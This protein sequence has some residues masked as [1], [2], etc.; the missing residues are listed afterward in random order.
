[1]KS[2]RESLLGRIPHGSIEALE[3]RRV[4]AADLSAEILS[5]VAGATLGAGTENRVVIAVTNSGT[6]G[7]ASRAGLA[8]YASTDGTFDP[9]SD[10]L[11][12]ART[13]SALSAGERETEDI[14]F[15]LPTNLTAGTYQLFAR[16]DG[17]NQ[18]QESDETNNVSAAVSVTL[19]G[20]GGGS[21]GTDDH[22]GGGSGGSDDNGGGSGGGS[23]GS[24][25][26]GG[27]SGGSD[28]S[29]GGSGGGSGG[30]D[31]NGGGSG[32][33]S[34][35]GSDL[36]VTMNTPSALFVPNSEQH[37][38]VSMTN[39][40]SARLRGV[41]V[42]VYVMTGDVADPTVDTLLGRRNFSS[43]SAGET[44]TEDVEFRVPGTVSAGTRRIYAVADPSN[45]VTETTESNNISA[46]V[47]ASFD[48]AALDLSGTI[49]SSRISSN[50]VA[51][52]ATKST[53]SYSIH[54]AG[55][56]QF[57]SRSSAHVRAY[58]RPV[59][60]DDSSQDIPVSDLKRENLS[61]L[62]PGK[63]RSRELKISIPA[64]VNPGE[65]TLVL[66]FDDSDSLH[67]SDEHNNAVHLEDTIRIAAP[68]V[69]LSASRALMT[70]SLASGRG[71]RAEA[72]VTNSGNV[73]AKGQATITFVLRT[74]QGQDTVIGT[75]TRKIEIKAGKISSLGKVTLRLP[76]GLAAGNYTLV[77]I[78]S[79]ASSLNDATPDNNSV[80]VGPV[81]IG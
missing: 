58:L 25:D 41:G 79:P 75:V 81:Q 69:D 30:S 66:S 51:G 31:D 49:R 36:T 18:H 59:G 29:G 65:Y 70:G 53:L 11:L 12:G 62:T 5:P 22:G 63:S 61:S 4:L 48:V 45:L 77:A 24:D 47:N 7:L 17:D 68:T 67:E 80:I 52:T 19:G 21:G 78:V 71:A 14:E 35:S 39:T 42:A 2:L 37:V 72:F 50:I 28:D 56:Q 55:N 76:A 10:T 60:V 33:G 64:G 23:G 57:E 73:K 74:E 8:L 3:T 44:E 26:N 9:A 16:V 20:S 34:G 15:V 38:L 32:G 13:I 54:N 40:G 46:P 43:L 6:T 27:G 1:M